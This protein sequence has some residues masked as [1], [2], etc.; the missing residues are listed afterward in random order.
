MW[1]VI[2]DIDKAVTLNEMG[3]MMV[4]FGDR[5]TASLFFSKS[6]DIS[7]QSVKSVFEPSREQVCHSLLLQLHHWCVYVCMCSESTVVGSL[8][9]ML[10]W[11]HDGSV[12]DIGQKLFV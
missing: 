4:M 12:A 5:Y 10:K 1:C 11:V 9:I 7:P 3:R 2:A 6:L 8:C